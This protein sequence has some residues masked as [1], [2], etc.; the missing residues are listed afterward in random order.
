MSEITLHDSLTGRTVAV[1]GGASGI[2][3]FVAEDLAW[4]GARIVLVA[5]SAAR[6]RTARALL[7]RPD[8]HRILTMDL[9]DAA[10]VRSAGTTLGQEASLHA[11]VLNAGVIDAPRA[12]TTGPYGVE[13]TVAVNAL[14]H[15]EL[16]GPAMPA[17]E[18]AGTARVVSTGSLLTRRISFDRANWLGQRAYEPRTAYAMSRHVAEI[19]GFEL[20]RRLAALGS[21]VTSVVAHPGSAIDVLTPD[22][23]GIHHR[24]PVV[25]RLATA[26]GPVVA[27]IVHG[28]DR[29]ARP[30]AAAVAATSLP[31]L[32]YVGPHRTAVGRPVLAQPV[33]STAD[34]HLGAWLWERAEEIIGHPVLA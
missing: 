30:A 9:T 31:R 32:A 13:W 26:L 12:R 14:A 6:A 3:Y 29:A 10:S 2:G 19:L 24:G 28:K 16:L 23:E 11:L 27:P 33:P 17:L 22:R 7:P 15:L 4:R 5:R 25:R 20:G 8:T 34:P 21:A 1:T 18:R